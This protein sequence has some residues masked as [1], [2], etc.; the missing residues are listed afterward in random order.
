MNSRT[1]PSEWLP[2]YNYSDYSKWPGDWELIYGFPYAM[3]PSP[4]GLIRIWEEILLF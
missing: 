1:I 4:K 3:S 2:N